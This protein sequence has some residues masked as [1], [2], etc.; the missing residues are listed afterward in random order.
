MSDPDRL[1]GALEEFKEA[2]IEANRINRH[3]HKEMM[4]EIHK[5]KI[6]QFKIEGIRI[7]LASIIAAIGAFLFKKWF[8]I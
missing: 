5:L 4:S 6:W 1:L 7:T 8:D 3:E 2:Q